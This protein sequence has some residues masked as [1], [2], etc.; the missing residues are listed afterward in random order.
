VRQALLRSCSKLL[1][2]PQQIIDSVQ[3]CVLPPDV[4]LESKDILT[5]ASIERGERRNWGLIA[6]YD[7][8]T[9]FKLRPSLSDI[10]NCFL[11]S[12]RARRENEPFQLIGGWNF[13]SQDVCARHVTHVHVRRRSTDRRF[14]LADR[15]SRSAGDEAV[16]EPVRARC[17]RVVNLSGAERSVNVP[18]VDRRHV[19]IWVG[20]LEVAYGAICETFRYRVDEE[21]GRIGLERVFGRLWVVRLRT[22]TTESRGEGRYKVSWIPLALPI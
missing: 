8:Q 5:R 7:R 18:W 15:T 10:L 12:E 21:S 19:Y 4:I 11:P 17:G 1:F 13:E 2:D 22:C 6:R 20:A 14:V 3:N 16:D 9:S